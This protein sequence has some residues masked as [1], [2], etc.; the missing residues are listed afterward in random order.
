MTY[1][2]LDLLLCTC[3]QVMRCESARL[4]TASEGEKSCLDHHSPDKRSQLELGEGGPSEPSSSTA[5]ILPPIGPQRCPSPWIPEPLFWG[6]GVMA[7]PPSP[8]ELHLSQ[9]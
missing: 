2:R 3:C 4:F 9:T 5:Q 7:L 8:R 6:G 1:S